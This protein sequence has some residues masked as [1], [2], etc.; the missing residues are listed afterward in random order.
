MLPGRHL[1]VTNP[2]L[3]FVKSI[4]K[5]GKLIYAS[6]E[7][8]VTGFAFLQVLSLDRTVDE[9][10]TQLRRDLLKLVGV[11][12][13]SDEAQWVDPCLSY[14]LSEVRACSFHGVLACLG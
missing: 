1:K 11:N 13:F 3:E 8:E 2:T 4:C 14:V 9:E 6:S 12:E 10:V 5:V 7:Y